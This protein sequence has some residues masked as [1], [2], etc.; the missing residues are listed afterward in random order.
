MNVY[1]SANDLARELK[2][3]PDV[4]EYRKASEKINADPNSK[5]MVEDFRKKQLEIYSMQAQGIKPSKEQ[6]DGINNL[7]KVISM[8]AD[9]KN[10]LEAEMKFSTL[11]ED[12]MKILGDAVGV[13]FSPDNEK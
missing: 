4:I 1:D 9:V 7:F 3:S 8:N 12:I 13:N 5:K 6:I 2:M 11:W 10:F